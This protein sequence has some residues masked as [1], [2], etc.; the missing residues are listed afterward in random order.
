MSVPTTYSGAEWSPGFGVRDEE[1]C[2][3]GGGGG[4]K[5]AGIV[6][7]PELTYDLPAGESAGTA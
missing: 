7:E 6:Y 2:V 3:K 1:R 4:A 5:L